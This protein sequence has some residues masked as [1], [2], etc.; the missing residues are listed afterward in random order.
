MTRTLRSFGTTLMLVGLTAVL[1]AQA[2]KANV[3][4]GLWEMTVV[5]Q[6]SGDMPG[7]DTSKMSDAQK[8]Q[9]AAMMKD[10]MKPRTDTSQTCITKDKLDKGTLFE[11]DK[12]KCT[13]T[14]VTNT[15]T[16]YSVKETCTEDNGTTTNGTLTFTATSSTAWAGKMD[17]VVTQGKSKTNATGTI[18]GKYLG[19][20]CGNVK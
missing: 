15:E 19:A 14:V 4:L 11:S 1:A 17:M 6:I 8:A 5:S 3:K 12:Q 9:M 13:R 2:P 7:M 20:D 10:M 18:T 16:T